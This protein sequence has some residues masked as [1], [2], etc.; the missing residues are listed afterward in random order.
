MM[1]REALNKILE[2]A[3]ASL[4]TEAGA[5]AAPADAPQHS[6][7]LGKLHDAATRSREETASEAQ[8]VTKGAYAIGDP[9]EAKDTQ[10]IYIPAG[11]AYQNHQTR[12]WT[13][14]PNEA[15]TAAEGNK[16]WYLHTGVQQNSQGEITA[17][18]IEVW[19]AARGGFL[20]TGPRRWIGAYLDVTMTKKA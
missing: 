2:L 16:E 9:N 6:E 8:V 4:G 7:F 3:R 19:A 5:R 14:N 1:E 10:V 13:A 20:G 11:W 12:I 15:P 17:V 18:W